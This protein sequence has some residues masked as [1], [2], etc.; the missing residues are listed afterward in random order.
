MFIYMLYTV[1]R[2]V[3]ISASQFLTRLIC[4][5]GGLLGRDLLLTGPADGLETLGEDRMRVVVGGVHVVGILEGRQLW[6][7]E[8]IGTDLPLRKG[9]GFV[10]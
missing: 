1:A 3:L 9:S 10:V 6:K 8:R 2:V 4:L 7:E 5:H